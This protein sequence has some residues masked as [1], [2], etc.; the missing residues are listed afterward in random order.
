MSSKYKLAV[1][2]IAVSAIALT[3]LGLTQARAEDGTGATSIVDK[4]A[5]RFS[6]NKDDVQKVFD[7]NRTEIRAEKEQSYLDRLSQAVTDGKLTTEQKDKLVAKHAELETFMTSLQGKTATE[8][9]AAMDTKRTE[10]EKWATDND[11]PDGYLMM[12]GGRG[13]HGPEGRGM[14]MGR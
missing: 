6:L 3:G 11:V 9:R 5:S 7:E 2:A 4:I 13:G 1:A 8:R 10:L 14:R 12:M